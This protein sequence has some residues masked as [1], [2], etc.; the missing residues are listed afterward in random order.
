MTA[1]H[2][3]TNIA[4]TN[5]VTT[6]GTAIAIAVDL[7]K[8]GFDS[9]EDSD[10]EQEIHLNELTD[11]I[12]FL[13]DSAEAAGIADRPVVVIGSDFSRTPFYNSSQGQASL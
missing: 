3:E 13:W 10:P 7:V 8:G 11:G 5:N 12:D 2:N 4:I 9:H 1:T 6:I